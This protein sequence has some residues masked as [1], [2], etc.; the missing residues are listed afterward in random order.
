MAEQFTDESEIDKIESVG[1]LTQ[2]SIDKMKTEALEYQREQTASRAYVY[3]L[4]IG[5]GMILMGIIIAS[6]TIFLGG[7]VGAGLLL[8][9]TIALV[10]AA[11]VMKEKL[12]E[13]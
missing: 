12:K 10:T 4:I 1:D 6:G 3:S 7:L 2:D 5:L 8:M 11:G 9:S 13:I